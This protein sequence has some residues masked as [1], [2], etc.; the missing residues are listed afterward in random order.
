MAIRR[1]ALATRREALGFTQETLAQELGVELSTIGRWER[2]T[3]TPQPWRRPDLAKA[4]KLSLEQL[5][6]LLNPPGSQIAAGNWPATRRE[7]IVDAAL[8]TSVIVADHMVGSR[9]DESEPGVRDKLVRHRTTLTSASARVTDLH[10]AYQAARYGDVTRRLPSLSLAVDALVAEGPAKERREA[11]GLQCS[12]A[13][14]AAKL[15]AK[16]GDVGAGWAAAEQ[17]R[18][19]AEAAED[20]FGHAA[21]AYQRACALLRAGRGEVAE[22]VAISGADNMQGRDPQSVTWQGTLT[23]IGAIIAARRNDPA[24]AGERLDHADELAP[25]R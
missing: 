16:A 1:V 25:R 24:E 7:V 10:R 6:R 12:V 17:A 2:G 22:Q 18:V 9:G 3:L 4:L 5:D 21:A 8:L 23:L 15:A 14:V 13:V 11:F 19:A 20:T